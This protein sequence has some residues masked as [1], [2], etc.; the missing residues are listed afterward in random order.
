MKNDIRKSSVLVLIAIYCFA[1]GIV[2]TSINHYDVQTAQTTEQEKF[3]STVSVNLYCHT[4]QLESSVSNLNDLPSPNFKNPFKNL[5][6]F[7]KTVEQ[8]FEL[9][10][11]QY[12]FFSINLLIRYR[13][14]NIIF[15]FHCFW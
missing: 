7:N 8:F 9:A 15:P 11:T 13:K 10:F 6:A 14:T 1:I 12:E 4:T 5:W 2:T 3:L